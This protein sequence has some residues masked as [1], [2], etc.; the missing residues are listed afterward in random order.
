MEFA[1][2]L[3]VFSVALSAATA[4]FAVTAVLR[5]SR[6]LQ[7]IRGPASPP[8]KSSFIS[9]TDAWLKALGESVEASQP[10]P[11]PDPS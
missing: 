4:A 7:E 6:E 5:L 11:G 8:G 9:R 2:G 10:K 3:G 1:V